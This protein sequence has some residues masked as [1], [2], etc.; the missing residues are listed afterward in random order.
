MGTY[1][2]NTNGEYVAINDSP[3]R[4]AIYSP[5]HGRSCT[6]YKMKGTLHCPKRPDYTKTT[7]QFIVKAMVSDQL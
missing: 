6:G 5:I 4:S 2:Q 1:F 3:P 7:S